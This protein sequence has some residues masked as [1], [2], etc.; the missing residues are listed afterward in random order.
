[1]KKSDLFNQNSIC[2]FTDSSFRKNPN[3][4]QNSAI[5]ITAPA[6]CVYHNNILINQGYKILV[7]STSQQG[8]LYAL[9]L[10]IMVC[11]SY[12]NFPYIRIFSDNQNAV[13]SVRDRIFQ[14]IKDTN[15]GI[16]VLG[17]DGRI[18]NQSYIMDIINTILYNDIQIELYHVK[19]HVKNS[20]SSIHN[21]KELFK[22]SNYIKEQVPDDL[23][24]QIANGNNTVDAYSTEILDQFLKCQY[25]NGTHVNGYQLALSSEYRPFDESQYESLINSY[26]KK[27]R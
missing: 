27:N 7:N 2:I 21:A 10:G 13:F 9:Y 15:D 4:P 16:P 17:F 3:C 20:S 18:K 14:W 25:I 12:R 1:M 19:G 23:I 26:N 6:Y 8:E 5:G 24:I 11:R 22:L